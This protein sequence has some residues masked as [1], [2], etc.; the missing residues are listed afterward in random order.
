VYERAIERQEILTNS[1]DDRRN[2]MDR[3]IAHYVYDEEDMELKF[4]N[5][6]WL[7]NYEYDVRGNA[8]RQK[9]TTY[10][11][12]GNVVNFQVIENLAFDLSGNILEQIVYTYDEEGG[13]LLNVVNR[14][15]DPEVPEKV[16]IPK[17]NDLKP[18][19]VKGQDNPLLRPCGLIPSPD[20]G[21]AKAGEVLQE[22]LQRKEVEAKSQQQTSDPRFCG[23][24][25]GPEAKML[26]QNK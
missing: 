4:A 17:P 13:T 11:E 14:K 3:E 9:I 2:V 10:D 5:R 18:E 21:P 26:V 25:T 19:K 22:I 20:P 16:L 8:H 23:Q 24:M 6:Q 12:D 1:F 7:R 15:I